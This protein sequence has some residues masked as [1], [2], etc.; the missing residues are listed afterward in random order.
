MVCAVEIDALG[1]QWLV[2]R[3]K[4]VSEVDSGNRTAVGKAISDVIRSSARR[5]IG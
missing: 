2:T 3:V 4:A 5:D 1:L